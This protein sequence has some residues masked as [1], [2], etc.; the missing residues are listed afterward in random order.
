MNLIYSVGNGPRRGLSS[1][2]RPNH[3]PLGPEPRSDRFMNLNLVVVKARFYF[4]LVLNADIDPILE[5]FIESPSNLCVQINHESRH[6]PH[7]TDS[8]TGL[9]R[10]LASPKQSRVSTDTS[11]HHVSPCV[12]PATELLRELPVRCERARAGGYVSPRSRG[13]VSSN[14]TE[15]GIGLKTNSELQKKY[16]G[17]QGHRPGH[18]SPDTFRRR[19]SLP[20]FQAVGQPCRGPSTLTT[21]LKTTV[22]AKRGREQEHMAFVLPIRPKVVEG[23]FDESLHSRGKPSLCFCGYDYLCHLDVLVGHD[24]QQ[25]SYVLVSGCG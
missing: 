15:R 14:P 16:L 18:G 25:S 17:P 6:T 4:Y 5:I 3:I 10:H 24:D 13:A 9:N 21:T 22:L 7:N 19:V 2:D 1:I 8:T 12:W 11:H 20:I 23:R